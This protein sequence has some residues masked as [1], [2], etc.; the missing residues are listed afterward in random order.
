MFGGGG[1]F[2]G[3]FGGQR[4]RQKPKLE[5]T[6]LE[7]QVTLEDL[8]YGKSFEIRYNGMETCST[9][10]GKGGKNVHKCTTCNGSGF[11][12]KSR[13]MGGMIMQSQEICGTC[14]G[15]GEVITKLKKK[16]SNC[17]SNR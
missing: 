11:V 16:N 2:G 7:I 9:C 10:D 1:P 8:F 4:S 12:I 6:M 3:G 14:G 15:S 13:N 17:I 5:P